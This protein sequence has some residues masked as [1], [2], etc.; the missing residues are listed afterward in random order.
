MSRA[1]LADVPAYR[2]SLA[3][4]MGE[5]QGA[6]FLAEVERRAEELHPGA[7]RLF[8]NWLDLVGAA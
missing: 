6:E 3:E 8:G 7:R 1:R 5:S 2:R 4:T